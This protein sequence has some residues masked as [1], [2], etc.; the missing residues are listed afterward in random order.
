[1]KNVKIFLCCLL[2]LWGNQTAFGQ[3]PNNYNITVNQYPNCDLASNGRLSLSQTTYYSAATY[4]WS[5]GSTDRTQ[6]GLAPGYYSVTVTDPTACIYSDTFYLPENPN[7]NQISFYQ[8]YCNN[9]YLQAYVNSFS[10]YVWSS[11]DIGNLIQNP[12]AGTYTVTATD[13]YGCQLTG[14]TTVAPY[15]ALNISHTTTNAT[16][17]NTDGTVDLTVSGGVAPYTFLWSIGSQTTEDISNAPVGT[18]WVRV[19]DA[20]NCTVWYYL[21]VYGPQVTLDRIPLSCGSTNNGQLSAIPHNLTNPSYLWNTGAVTPTISGLVSGVYSVTVTDGACVLTASRTINN[22]GSPQAYIQADS[23]SLNLCQPDSLLAA[24]WGGSGVFS[25]LWSTGETTSTLYN[26]MQGVTYSVTLTDVHGGCSSATSFTV[27]AP[28]TL[29]AN[30]TAASCGASDGAIDLTVNGGSQPFIF[31]WQPGSMGTEDISNLSA[32]SYAVL[33]YDG[34]GCSK[35]D[36]F[37]V[38]GA[39]VAANI[40]NASCAQNNGRIDLDISSFSNAI[41]VWSNGSTTASISGLAA[42]S[43]SVT[44]SDANCTI[45]ES[46]TVIDGGQLTALIQSQSTCLPTYL[47]AIG[48]GAAAPYTY[49][50]S[51]GATTALINNPIPGN[52]YVVTVT[53]ANGCTASASYLVP[54]PPPITAVETITDAICGNKNGRIDLTV[55]GGSLPFN[56]QWSIGTA[57]VQNLIGIYPGAYAVTISDN[58]GCQ[59]VLN[60]IV[61]GG[62]GPSIAASTTAADCSNMNGAINI[63]VSN[64]TNPSYLWS[65]GATTEDISGLSSGW[66]QVVATDGGNGCQLTKSIRVYQQAN[67]NVNTCISGRIYDVTAFG[68]CQS[69]G[70]T[71][72]YQMVV[73][74][75]GNI[76][77]FTN[78]N[79]YYS[80]SGIVAAGTYTVDI[81]LGA[82][83]TSLCPSS[84]SI[85]VNVT[86]LGHCYSGNNF[87]VTNPPVQDL[88]IDIFHVTNATPGFEYRTRVKYKN[89]GNT[90]MSG[91]LDNIY[92]PLL[93]FHSVINPSTTLDLHDIPNHK[94]DWSFTNLQPGESRYVYVDFMVPTSATLGTV[95]NHTGTILPLVGD[96]VPADNTDADYT[97]IVGSWD[98]NDKRVWPFHSNSEHTGG[99]IYPNEEEV[100]HLPSEWWC[101][102]PSMLIYCRKP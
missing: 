66:Y 84:N 43:Y 71:M 28:L 8:N 95:L 11:G 7:A 4:L 70:I 73:L 60:N 64:I 10:S 39:S 2:F 91:T 25:Y 45:T 51:S 98:P 97:T 42:G 22:G 81:V 53:D 102:I 101:E 67:C 41:Y 94:F 35:R 86:S 15:N 5:N 69:S 90:I 17:N 38:G 24:G 19:R 20:N 76:I 27:G 55:S 50:W 13:I 78:S 92:N 40:T 44:V 49:A 88:M 74:N 14:S 82:G 29:S 46:F 52:S 34:S 47:V 58:A 12:V 96:A 99:I 62:A 48:Q 63:S 89:K 31:N 32:G 36:T 72:D 68:A 26:L 30:I 56:Y 65:N 37:V 93:G 77:G 3:C 83:S 6:S 79:G 54:N 59:F 85:A 21:D 9:P 57:N 33:I 75:P 18:H 16:C 80:F 23:F 1:M 61:V 100:L 87:Y